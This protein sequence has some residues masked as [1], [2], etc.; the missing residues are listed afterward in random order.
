M[1]VLWSFGT[2]VNGCSSHNTNEWICFG[3]FQGEKMH[4]VT[5]VALLVFFLCCGGAEQL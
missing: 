2:Y 5:A 1:G 3:S 4:T